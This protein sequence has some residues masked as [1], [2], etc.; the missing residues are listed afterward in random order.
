MPRTRDQSNPLALAVLVLLFERPMHPYEIAAT[1]RMRNKQGSIKINY[2]S[3]YTVIESLQRDR[4][5]AVKETV[6]EGRRP[7]R[8]IYQ[9][10]PA[11]LERMRC[12]LREMLETPV[13]EYPRFEAALAL[14][15][16]IPPDEAVTLL[17]AR[18]GRLEEIC[19]E[20]RAT[21]EAVSKVV[22]PLF[23]VELEYRLTLVESEQQFIHDLL[24]RVAENQ[25]YTRA[26]KALHI[27]P[28]G[29]KGSEQRLP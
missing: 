28:E 22:E 5:I 6:R 23:L 10:T 7:E 18:I 20:L 27:K 9:I 16:A 21:I 24:R 1:L 11:G 13:K 19:E 12:W 8:T 4:L 25:D 14:L 2:G 17:E 29:D 26:W 3:L 15:P